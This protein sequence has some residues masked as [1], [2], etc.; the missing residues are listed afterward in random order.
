M[1]IDSKTAG[2][3]VPVQ[4]D[5][6]TLKEGAKKTFTKERMAEVGLA[7]ATFVLTGYL[8]SLLFKGIETYSMSRF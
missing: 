6:E 7:T 4:T 8:G 2:T 1:K 5:T 3:H